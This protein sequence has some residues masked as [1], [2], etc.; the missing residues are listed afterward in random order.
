MADA[1]YELG[2]WSK[3]ID[4]WQKASERGY[5]RALAQYNIA[6]VY[7]RLG[8][9]QN[10]AKWLLAAR[11]S[12]LTDVEVRLRRDSDFDKVRDQ[13]VFVD[14]V[15]P[16]LP[17][18]AS[19]EEKWRT[20]IDF[21]ATRVAESHYD[22]F[23]HVSSARWQQQTGELKQQ[24]DQLSDAEVYVRLQQ[25]LGQV[26]D[27]HSV[28]VPPLGG[29][30]HFHGLPLRLTRFKDGVYIQA[31][32]RQYGALVG[33][34]LTHINGQPVAKVLQGL[35]SLFQGDNQYGADY[36]LLRWFAT[37][38]EILQAL[39]LGGQGKDVK[40]GVLDGQGARTEV[41]VSGKLLD[42]RQFGLNEHPAEWLEMGSDKSPLWQQQRESHYWF[43][44]LKDSHLVYFKYNRVRN[45]RKAPLDQFVREVI[46]KA[47]QHKARLV[48]D[49]RSNNGGNGQ[50]NALLL[51]ALL[52][53][54]INQRGRLFVL[55]GNK[56][57]SAAHQLALSLQY[58]TN[59]VFVG[60]PTGSSL[61]YRGE[62]NQVLLPNTGLMVMVASRQ[63]QQQLSDD[64][65]VTLAP[66]IL[67]QPSGAQFG[68]GQDPVLDAVIKMR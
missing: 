19:R 50:L 9:G 16:Q 57:F 61:V 31:A 48:I 39:G 63:F 58:H 40:L 10:A 47:E 12:K 13:A 1:Q 35:K 53:S 49:L 29:M 36:Q 67:V 22:L 14:K 62:S 52:A 54:E 6:A 68:A 5:Q 44:Y 4:S 41:T 7:G 43:K 37:M 64:H 8:D 56:T 20:D 28:V 60:E 34:R 51:H 25:L 66:D 65:R 55:I 42:G 32:D 24:L 3:A 15:W 21:F 2:E 17:A 59:A 23:D 45:D 30:Q 18:Q 27:G 38:P 46:D 26:K 11:A 33:Q